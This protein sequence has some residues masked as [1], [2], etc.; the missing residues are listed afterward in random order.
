MKKGNWA[1]IAFS[2]PW[3]ISRLLAGGALA[4]ETKGSEDIPAKIFGLPVFLY[5]VLML[6]RGISMAAVVAEFE[7]SLSDLR[8]NLK[9]I[10]L[11]EEQK[12]TIKN[13]V[14]FP[15]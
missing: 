3:P 11:R 6:Q 2:S 10:S 9:N 5:T 4:R 14:Y 12:Q 15:N 13:I 7:E 8:H 1:K